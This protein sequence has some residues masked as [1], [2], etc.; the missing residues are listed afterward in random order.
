MNEGIITLTDA[1][2]TVMPIYADR[3]MNEDPIIFTLL[4][5]QQRVVAVKGRSTFLR[6]YNSSLSFPSPSSCLSRDSFG[7]P[8]PWLACSAFPTFLL[9]QGGA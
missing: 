3:R 9:A 1:I 5:S 8:A 4:T 2:G 6:Y 7:T